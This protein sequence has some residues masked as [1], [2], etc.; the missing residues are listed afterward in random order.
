M[1][2]DG[3]GQ[4]AYGDPWDD[5]IA[6]LEARD[7]RVRV[8]PWERV[9]EARIRVEA[10]ADAGE[11]SAKVR[12]GL[13]S[14][15]SAEGELG[16]LRPRSVVVG[17]QRRPMTQAALV[18]RGEERLVRVPP[19][20]RGY[21]RTQD[22]FAGLGEALLGVAG[23]SAARATV[24]MK[25]LAVASGLARYGHNTVAY[26]PGLGSYLALAAFASDAPAPDGT[27][28]QAPARLEQCARCSACVRACPTQAI[29]PDDGP[30]RVHRCLTYLNEGSAPFPDW[31]DARAHRCAVGCMRC[32]EVCPEN[33]VAGLTVDEPVRFDEAETALILAGDER[34][35]SPALR[36]RL[37][38]CGLDYLPA[39][40]ARNVR[41][42][43]ER[44][45]S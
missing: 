18:W 26:V 19:H 38:R 13:A 34:A 36:E 33:V 31:L 41:L 4:M 20:Y 1:G 35:C 25:T 43:L 44:P 24:P 23:C 10:A 45:P 8:L 11:Y 12:D 29:P 39:V 9:D 16:D 3:G 42:L 21:E 32:Q 30:L 22:E 40:I 6:A 15:L 37:A 5:V 14:D 27:P 17:A 7:W 28:W 2:D